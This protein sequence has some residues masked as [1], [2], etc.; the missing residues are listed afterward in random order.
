MNCLGCGTLTFILILLTTW[1]TSLAQSASDP[2]S[3]ATVLLT[4]TVTDNRKQLVSGLTQSAF[5]LSD[6]KGIREITSFSNGDVP[7][8]IA[9]LFDTSGSIKGLDGRNKAKSMVEA[10][11]HFVQRSH[12]S[13]EYFVIGF[14]DKPH[15]LLDR[16]RDTSGV[17]SLLQQLTF[18]QSRGNTALFDAFVFAIDKVTSGA[19]PKQVILLISDGKDNV[20]QS[21]LNHVLRLLKE[22]NVLVYALDITLV[23]GEYIGN[24]P[25]NT[26][27]S[28]VLDELTSITGGVNYRT[29][30]A[31]EINTK[32]ERIGFELR[33]QYSVGFSAAK[34]A[35]GSKWHPLKVEVS[36]PTTNSHDVQ[37]LSS[38]SQKGYYSDAR[39]K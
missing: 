8:S 34:E 10:L 20:S 28:Q 13:N 17:S 5:T 36:L 31:T 15:L 9:I 7:I 38:R 19:Y 32:L 11:S 12:Q 23:L 22:K 30:N 14:N 2:P 4:V 24:D 35:S 33:H 6:D 29:D 3:S 37:K 16:T 18:A 26:E 21:T 1:N 25:F 39:K 27:G